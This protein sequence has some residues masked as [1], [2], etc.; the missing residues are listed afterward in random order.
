MEQL[1]RPKATHGCGDS[2]GLQGQERLCLRSACPCSHLVQMLSDD[3]GCCRCLFRRTSHHL[4]SLC[5]C[6]L[7]K[8]QKVQGQKMWLLCECWMLSAAVKAF[9]NIVKQILETMFSQYFMGKFWIIYSFFHCKR[10]GILKEGHPT[11]LG[12]YS[13]WGDCLDG[14][15]KYWAFF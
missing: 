4:S 8:S 2:R 7:I 10:N 13:H 11:I 5:R 14:F 6:R 15:P 9:E 12:T 3:A 1:A